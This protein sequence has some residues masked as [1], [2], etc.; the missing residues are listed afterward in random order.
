MKPL[1]R[2]PLPLLQLTALAACILSVGCSS[3]DATRVESAA[4]AVYQDAASVAGQ[5]L[6]A[7]LT[8]S[9]LNVGLDI[10]AG[11]EVGAAVAGIQGAASAMRDYEGMPTAP[12]SATV[13]R[14]AAAGAGVTNV[15]AALA[16]S[17]ENLVNK[18]RSTAAQQKIQIS[19]DDIIEAL[20]R[21]FDAVADA[22]YVPAKGQ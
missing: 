16:P 4:K 15:A 1:H 7:D 13:A 2:L 8:S 19:T 11:N 10:A 14:A 5:K 18:A 9:A 12:S 17:V 21:G 20:A 6:L 3:T 22:W